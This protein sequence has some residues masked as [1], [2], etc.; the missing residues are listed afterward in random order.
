[1]YVQRALSD[2]MRRASSQFPAVLLTGP[3]QAGKSTF[4]RHEFPDAAYLSFDDPIERQF[5]QEDPNGFLNRFAERMI[6]LDEVQYVPDLFPYLKI[7]I[8]RDR[9]R[10]GRYLMTG[11]QQFQ[12][13]TRVSESLAG[14]VAILDLLPFHVLE[15]AE[16]G[17]LSIEE[18]LWRGGYPE[19]ALAPEKREF[20]LSS[21]IR[22]YIE[23]DIRE[24]TA[25]QDIGL[26]QTFLG[27]AAAAHGQ[28]LNIAR[29]ATACGISQPTCKRWLAILEASFLVLFLKPYHRNLSK[30][31]IKSPKFYFLDPAPVA[32]LTRQADPGSLFAGA[33]GG[34]F[35]EGFI[36]TET[37]KI[38]SS[39]NVNVALSFWRS[40]DQLEIDLIIEKDGVVWP[41]EIKKSATPSAQFATGVLKFKELHEPVAKVGTPQ[42]V[43][44]VAE[45][46][47]LPGGVEAV[48]WREYLAWIGSL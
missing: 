45:R 23:R 31:L 41:V 1:M 48:P 5:A 34:A 14:R 9:E 8:D 25:V 32:Y 16:I 12:T 2:A 44:M 24:I 46:R 6:I 42:V 43:C 29:L 3:R 11:S 47:P 39:R 21:Y 36:I 22:T 40:H 35:F 10:Y 19:P 38:L 33:M 28:E 15:M 4:L 7:R 13:M 20:W 18:H 30:R 26:F 37:Y 27:F 17:D